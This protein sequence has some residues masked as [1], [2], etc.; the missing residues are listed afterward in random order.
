[1]DNVFNNCQLL[2]SITSFNTTPP[3]INNVCFKNYNA[4][5]YVPSS[6]IDAYN[7]AENWSMFSNIIGL[8]SSIDGIADGSENGI[9]YSAPYEVYNIAGARIGCS[10]DGLAPA[11]YIVRQGSKTAKVIK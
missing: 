9:D 3:V 8:S 2:T 10:I 7:Q 1:M 5:L 4:T 11:I 6:A